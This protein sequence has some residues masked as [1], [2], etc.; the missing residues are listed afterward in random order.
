[1]S[2]YTFSKHISHE[3][4]DIETIQKGMTAIYSGLG[5]SIIEK[6]GTSELGRPLRIFMWN[7]DGGI[8]G[9]LTG[10][11]FGGWPYISL[12]WI[13]K[14]LRASGRGTRL[15]RMAEKEAAKAGYKNVHLDTYSFEARPFYEKLVY[16]LFAKLDDYP[17]GYCKY[18]LKKQLM[19]RL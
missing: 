17:P 15:M 8:V 5:Q 14:S 1:M 12:L 3:Q 7:R 6:T 2:D 18:F 16:Q 13:E 4:Q 9:G 10:T 11:M 19:P